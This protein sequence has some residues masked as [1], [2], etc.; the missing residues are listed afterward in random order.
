MD[1]THLIVLLFRL[2]VLLALLLWFG[3]RF[4]GGRPPRPM[5]PSPANDVLLIRKKRNRRLES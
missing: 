1:Q 5:H 3:S 4:R 2:V